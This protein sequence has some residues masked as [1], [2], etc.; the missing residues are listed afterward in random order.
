VRVP[1]GSCF[2]AA[3]SSRRK[4]PPPL[5]PLLLA[6]LAWNNLLAF[7][8]LHGHSFETLDRLL[9][10]FEMR[11]VAVHADTLTRLA[12]E[13][14]KARAAWEERLIKLALRGAARVRPRIAPWFDAFYAAP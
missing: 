12:D 7:P 9:A 1:S 14:T 3:M 5:R 10:R 13:R 6:A 8:Y 4:L 11:R 2:R